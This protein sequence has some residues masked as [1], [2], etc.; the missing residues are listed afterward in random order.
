MTLHSAKGL[1][2]PIVFL[3]GVEEDLLPHSGMQG[4]WQIP[5]RSGGWPTSGSRGPASSST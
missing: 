2:W 4:R 3:A 1:E 5:T